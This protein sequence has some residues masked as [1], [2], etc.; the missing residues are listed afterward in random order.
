[1]RLS[2]YNFTHEKETLFMVLSIFD[3]DHAGGG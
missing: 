1:V 3:E 2:K